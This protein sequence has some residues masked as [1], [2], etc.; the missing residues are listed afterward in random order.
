MTMISFLRMGGPALVISAALL[1]MRDATAQTAQSP[2][3]TDVQEIVVEG[4]KD[5]D[6]IHYASMRRALTAFQT[7]DPGPRVHMVLR[8]VAKRRGLDPSKIHVALR[9]SDGFNRNL[10]TFP[11]GRI[12]VPLDPEALQ[13]KPDF[14]IYAKPGDIRTEINV[15]I[16]TK[17]SPTN[18]RT[19]MDD[20]KKANDGERVLMSPMQ[21]LEFPQSNALA[22]H[23]FG[24]GQLEIQTRARGVITLKPDNKHN[25][26]LPR[27]PTLYEENPTVTITGDAPFAMVTTVR[28]PHISGNT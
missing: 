9:G 12:D 15:V 5:P 20:M 21:R 23:Y 13:A 27:D 7:V 4:M 8:I 14:V 26:T 6:L 19:L 25:I 10:T 11:G 1:M 17:T 2:M 3:A 22:I 16:D 18:Y 28:N 24:D